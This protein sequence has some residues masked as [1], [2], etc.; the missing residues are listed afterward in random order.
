L[1]YYPADLKDNSLEEGHYPADLTVN[2]WLT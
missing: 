1:G 2:T